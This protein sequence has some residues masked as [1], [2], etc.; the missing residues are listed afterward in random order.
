MEAIHLKILTEWQVVYTGALSPHTGDY[1]SRSPQSVCGVFNV[2]YMSLS[3]ELTTFR[4]AGSLLLNWASGE[5]SVF[6]SPESIGYSNF[7]PE[8]RFLSINLI[9]S[10]LW[11]RS[12]FIALFLIGFK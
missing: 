5:L 11:L 1:V 4:V 2:P 3:V 12:S 10:Q 7:K 6:H 9:F 8:S